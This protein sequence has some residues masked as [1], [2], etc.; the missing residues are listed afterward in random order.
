L[1]LITPLNIKAFIF[2]MPGGGMGTAFGQ[3]PPPDLLIPVSHS[4]GGFTGPVGTNIHQSGDL[5]TSMVTT[6]LNYQVIGGQSWFGNF[7]TNPNPVRGAGH[8]TVAQIPVPEPSPMILAVIGLASACGFRA[9]WRRR[10][11][12]E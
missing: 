6:D 3:F 1:G 2:L 8:W 4:D 12:S 9:V 5:G 10:D 11:E 7:I